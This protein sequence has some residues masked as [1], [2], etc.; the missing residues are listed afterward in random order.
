MLLNILQCLGLTPATKNYLP[1][2]SIVLRL[3][4]SALASCYSKRLHCK[5]LSKPVLHRSILHVTAGKIICQSRLTKFRVPCFLS[6]Y[7]RAVHKE[8]VQSLVK[9]KNELTRKMLVVIL[10]ELS[11]KLKRKTATV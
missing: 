8:R 9:I 5:L 6:P 11:N 7:S 3:R 10:F 4:H 2:T 1:Q